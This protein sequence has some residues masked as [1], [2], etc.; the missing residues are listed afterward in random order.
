LSI[1]QVPSESAAQMTAR[2]AKLFEGGTVT[3]PDSLCGCIVKSIVILLLFLRFCFFCFFYSIALNILQIVK[4][5][6]GFVLNVADADFLQQDDFQ[7]IVQILFVQC[8][9][10]Q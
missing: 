4:E 3:V 7:M 2:C 1:L 8:H 9:D 5:G 6:D 10:R